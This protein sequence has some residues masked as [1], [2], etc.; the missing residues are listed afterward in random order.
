MRQ[1]VIPGTLA[2]A[3]LASEEV[4]TV[5]AAETPTTQESNE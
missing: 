4:P 2:Y 5:S 3:F 1:T